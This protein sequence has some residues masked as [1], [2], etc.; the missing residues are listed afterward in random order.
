MRDRKAPRYQG[1]ITTWKDDEGFGFI[2]PNGGGPTVFVHIKSFASRQKRPAGNE[3]VTYILTANGAGKA[4]A[5]EVA[6]VGG[7]APQ[8]A[9][10]TGPPRL[11]IALAFLGLLGLFAALDKVPMRLFCAYLVLSVIAY[12]T[13][14]SDKSAARNNQWR[15]QE[16]TLQFLALAGGWPGALAAQHFLRHK[17]KKKSFLEVFW[18]AVFINCFLLAALLS[19]AGRQL[20][21]PLLGLP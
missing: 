14:A 11:L 5:E 12:V 10:V 21:A 20:C 2:T 6:F 19:P 8:A 18:G 9:P 13:Y 7:R 16:S 15:V 4:R 17:S 1:R 3:I